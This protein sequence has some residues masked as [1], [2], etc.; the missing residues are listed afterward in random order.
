MKKLETLYI[1]DFDI[2]SMMDKITGKLKIQV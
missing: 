1:E 2:F